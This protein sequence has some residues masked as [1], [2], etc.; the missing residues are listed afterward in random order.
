V[1]LPIDKGP[2]DAEIP[3]GCIS[4]ASP[5]FNGDVIVRGQISKKSCLHAHLDER[6]GGEQLLELLHSVRSHQ[7]ERKLGCFA[8]VG[9][10]PLAIQVEWLKPIVAEVFSQLSVP[11]D[12]VFT[13]QELLLYHLIELAV[14]KAE[15]TAAGHLSLDQV[16][17]EVVAQPC[18]DDGR[19]LVYTR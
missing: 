8:E 18:P 16:R 4:Q 3:K 19:Q 10:R 2:P 9:Q 6:E 1:V 17:F 12:A 13:S 14:E 7:L 15:R 11:L 5:L